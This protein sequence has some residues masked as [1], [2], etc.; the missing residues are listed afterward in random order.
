MS[1]NLYS[2]S[3]L[4]SQ[5]NY[6][7][8]N[9]PS[10]TNVR[11]Y[12]KVVN[13]SKTKNHLYFDLKNVDQKGNEIDNGIIHC[14]LFNYQS[15]EFNQNIQDGS[16]VLVLGNF[17]VYLNSGSFSLIILKLHIYT[18]DTVN[19]LFTKNL[20]ICEEKGYTKK[21]L[22][23]PYM[24]NKIGLIT[25]YQ[26]DAY[27]DMLFKI[28]ELW[29]MVDF[30]CFDAPMQNINNVWDLCQVI[31]KSNESDCDLLI[32]AR[33]G[34]N[35]EDL[36]LFNDIELAKTIYN[37]KIPMISGIGH[38]KDYTIVDFVVD[39]RQATPTAAIISVLV[40]KNQIQ[41]NL[42]FIN[43]QLQHQILNKYQKELLLQQKM[44][45]E[46]ISLVLKF[47]NI[48][49]SDLSQTKQILKFNLEK[50]FNYNKNNLLLNKEK[51]LLFENKF[52]Q[53]NDQLNHFRLIINAHNPNNILKKGYA[54]IRQNHK[55]IKMSSELDLNNEFEI[56]FNDQ[57]IKVGK[58][59]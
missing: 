48:I 6:F 49:S 58:Y 54:I 57:R 9:E 25:K 53:L 4:I 31:E 1:Q 21:K 29:P 8:K 20:K 41:K 22:N 40:D 28:N 44:K 59:E 50:Y 47:K 2:V 55:V 5:V 36:M 38:E 37:R 30:V 10:L 19:Q 17:N 24:P 42:N 56:Q 13:L 46:F 16:I 35:P 51:L 32:I 14:S 15:F 18:K 33:G 45:S 7:L 52:K 12:G 43:Q 23:I 34:G 27:N 3:S 26:S 11:V 39:D